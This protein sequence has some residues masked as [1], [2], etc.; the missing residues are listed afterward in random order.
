VAG[1]PLQDISLLAEPHKNFVVIMKA[2]KIHKDIRA[3]K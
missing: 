1:D 3:N 2:G